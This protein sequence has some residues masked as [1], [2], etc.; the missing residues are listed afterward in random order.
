MTPD[1]QN[2]LHV[3]QMLKTCCRDVYQGAITQTSSDKELTRPEV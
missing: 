1:I 2:V 3:L